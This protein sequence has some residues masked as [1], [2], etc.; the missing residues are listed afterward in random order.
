MATKEDPGKT[1]TKGA[2]GPG[3][4]T[5]KAPAK[6]KTVQAKNKPC[7]SKLKDLEK[8]LQ[9]EKDK[10]LRL[11]ADFD[12]YRKRTL[13]EK[14]DLAKLAGEDIF[15]KILPV[16]DDLERALKSVED[17]GDLK[18]VKEGI[19]LIYAKF[20]DYLNQQGVREIEALHKEFDTDVHEAVTKIPAP[21]KKLK[22]KIVDVIEKGY[23]LNEKVIRYAKVVI[24]E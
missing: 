6:K 7:E 1:V 10:Y 4:K 8:A 17:A 16:L 24:G 5:Q 20:A 22:G 12:N 15:V 14:M 11:S 3:S 13:K 9:E 21:E 23:V 2:T 19:Q 18:A